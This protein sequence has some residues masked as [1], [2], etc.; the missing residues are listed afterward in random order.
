MS[1]QHD[2]DETTPQGMILL[3]AAT[4]ATVTLVAVAAKSNAIIIAIAPDFLPKTAK[5]P[6]MPARGNRGKARFP[7]CDTT[8]AGQTAHFR[9][10]M[11]YG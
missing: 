9:F 1:Q 7:L 5:L 8:R 6:Y 3:A 4:M 10:Q 11:K 2:E